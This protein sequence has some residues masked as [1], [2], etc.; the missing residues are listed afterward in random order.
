[1][2]LWSV[3]GP[4]RVVHCGTC[5]GMLWRRKLSQR[6]QRNISFCNRTDS[7]VSVA[8][9]IDLVGTSETTSQ[10]WF[11]VRSCSCRSNLSA[12]LRTTEIFFSVTRDGLTNRLAMLTARSA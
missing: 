6:F 4:S 7:E 1:M 9:G 12:D 5:D 11:D 8:I 10:G 2:C 3:A